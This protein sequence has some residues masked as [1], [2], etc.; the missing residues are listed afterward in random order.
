MQMFKPQYVN[1]Q[2]D[3]QR[4]SKIQRTQNAINL[5]IYHPPLKNRQF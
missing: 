3:T 4:K 5:N 1:N 2:M